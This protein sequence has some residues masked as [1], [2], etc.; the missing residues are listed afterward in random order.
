MRL[1]K[2]RKINNRFIRRMVAAVVAVC[3]I[4][5]ALWSQEVSLQLFNFRVTGYKAQLNASYHIDQSL[6]DKPG[7]V[8]EN[9][10]YY[11]SEEISTFGAGSMVHQNLLNYQVGFG[12]GFLQS[13][14]DLFARSDLKKSQNGYLRSFSIHGRMLQHKPYNLSFYYTHYY[15]KLKNDLYDT[16]KDTRNKNWGGDLVYGNAYVPVKISYDKS[17]SERTGDSVLDNSET[18]TRSLDFRFLKIPRFKN[19]FSLSHAKKIYSYENSNN[20]ISE[21]TEANGTIELLLSHSKKLTL[22]SYIRW[23]QYENNQKSLN[24]N[25][26]ITDIPLI[27]NLRSNLSHMTSYYNNYNIKNWQHMGEINILNNVYESM[28]NHLDFTGL[29]YD[30]A[31]LNSTELKYAAGSNYHKNLKLGY[32][33]TNL[34]YVHSN[35]FYDYYDALYHYQN[36][37][38]HHFG[39][40]NY[41]IL[42]DPGILVETIKVTSLDGH[43]LYFLDVDYIVKPWGNQ[44]Q[45]ERTINSEIPDSSEVYINYEF[46]IQ[47]PEEVEGRHL[48]YGS[49]YNYQN[50]VK[51]KLGYDYSRSTYNVDNPYY[52][53]E[54]YENRRSHQ[55]N[56]ELGW[57]NYSVS[58]SRSKVYSN[59]NAYESKRIGCGLGFSL[60]KRHNFSANMSYSITDY[61]VADAVQE[62]YR[63]SGSY[64]IR[65]TR[66]LQGSAYG[67]YEDAYGDMENR[68][69]IRL[70]SELHYSTTLFDTSL[71]FVFNDF[72]QFENH[73]R[74]YLTKFKITFKY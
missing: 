32:L 1:K 42:P 40:E 53:S 49:S 27:F 17:Y 63:Y 61:T 38:T 35:R 30:Q 64:R 26:R 15:N 16:R 6:N 5:S 45:I 23:F 52:E 51:F 55:A 19:S 29:Y 41:V 68:K 8:D 11:S 25:D 44:I 69:E 39:Q 9:Q 13:Y 24:I 4:A 59:S 57:S 7:V 71:Q 48:S 67:S 2:L 31:G 21:T 34:N 46:E 20:F 62:S 73:R 37:I 58:A 28:T 3:M 54:Y 50:G 22:D 47:P 43:T 70:D 33:N 66:A 14:R 10:F 56:A 36:K 65:I 12:L 60:F 18:R 72:K 74:K